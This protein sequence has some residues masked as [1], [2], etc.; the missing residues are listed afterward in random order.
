MEFRIKCETFARLSNVCRYMKAGET[1]EYL[2][3]LYVERAAG[4]LIAIATNA[5]IAAIELLEAKSAEPD[6]SCF[7]RFDDALIKQCMNESKFNSVLHIVTNDALRWTAVKSMFGYEHP[8]NVGFYTDQGT[9]TA[10]WRKWMPDKMP[11]VSA[12]QMQIEAHLL[13]DLGRAAPS[14]ELVF[15]PYFDTG[16]PVMVRDQD[17]PKWY[18]F[19]MAAF[20]KKEPPKFELPNW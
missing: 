7:I 11:S 16:R 2:S 13:A 19:F 12:G 8:G 14:G 1:R 15:P 20:A 3:C 6:G 10:L 17:D 4:N 18:G 5:Q 9:S